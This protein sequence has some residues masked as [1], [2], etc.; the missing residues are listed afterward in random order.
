[1]S[2]EGSCS[3][4]SIEHD[5]VSSWQHERD[6]R[7]QERRLEGNVYWIPVPIGEE[8]KFKNDLVDP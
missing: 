6:K 1:M 2:L 7:S 5:V 4:E 3:D 8:L